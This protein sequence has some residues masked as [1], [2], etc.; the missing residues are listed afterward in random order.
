MNARHTFC[1]LTGLMAAVKRLKGPKTIL[2]LLSILISY[3]NKTYGSCF[4]TSFAQLKD[5]SWQEV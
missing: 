2:E 4:P 3:L 5:D 1:R